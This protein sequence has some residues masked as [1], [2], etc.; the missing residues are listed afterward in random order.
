MAPHKSDSRTS[1][2]PSTPFCKVCKDAGKSKEEYTS[3]YI[4]SKPGPDGVVVCPHL[5]SL[6]CRY[7]HAM[8]H[9]P[10]YCPKANAN[11]ERREKMRGTT[12][13][14]WARGT[15]AYVEYEQRHL[16]K[17]KRSS[18]ETPQPKPKKSTN[19]FAALDLDTPT[20]DVS[21]PTSIPTTK[22]EF[23]ALTTAPN[24]PKM[25]RKGKKPKQVSVPTSSWAKITATPLPDLPA[26]PTRQEEDEE[27]RR[28]EQERERE[29]MQK[30][31]MAKEIQDRVMQQANRSY[32]DE[33][34]EKSYILE[35]AMYDPNYSDDEYAS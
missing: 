9:T 20:A 12:S 25:K 19:K 14:V 33:G 4:L 11:N 22:E 34:E 13:E 3:H 18:L 24:A 26:N 7:C 21:P 28:L 10:K 31:A 27:Q 2:A 32:W 17:L 29:L 8:G 15:Q 30:M 5:L 1:R 16:A 23:P 35:D 6:E